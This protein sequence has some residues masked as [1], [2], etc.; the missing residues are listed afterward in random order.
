MLP[1]F[2][3]RAPLKPVPLSRQHSPRPQG[4]EPRRREACG[5]GGLYSFGFPISTK[6]FPMSKG[7]GSSVWQTRFC[8]VPP[9]RNVHTW[10]LGRKKIHFVERVA[11]PSLGK[12]TR[13]EDGREGFECLA[14]SAEDRVCVKHIRE[15]APVT[16]KEIVPNFPFSY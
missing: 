7:R 8:Y 5:T 3:Q 12:N 13:D 10:V 1:I 4:G 6:C 14:G 16:K 11:E 2:R 9:T 15:R